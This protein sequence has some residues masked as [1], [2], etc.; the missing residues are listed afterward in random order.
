MHE[1]PVLP[2]LNLSGDISKKHHLMRDLQGLVLSVLHSMIPCALGTTPNVLV[3]HGRTDWVEV[4]NKAAVKHVCLLSLSDVPEEV[5]SPEWQPTASGDCFSQWTSLKLSHMVHFPADSLDAFLVVDKSYENASSIS[6]QK[7]NGNSRWKDKKRKRSAASENA[8]TNSGPCGVAGAVEGVSL[9]DADF[10]SKIREYVLDGVSLGAN[11]YPLPTDE[12]SL[13][14]GLRPRAYSATGDLDGVL[15]ANALLDAMLGPSL[16][17][18]EDAFRLLEDCVAPQGCSTGYVQTLSGEHSRKCAPLVA[19]DCE[20]CVTSAG[21]P[22]LTRV[23]VVGMHG[24]V[25]LDELVKPYSPIVDY[26]TRF[27]GITPELLGPITTRIEQIQIAILRM[28]DRETIIVGHSL[29]NDLH[30]LKIAHATVVDTALIFSSNRGPEFKPA[31]RVLAREHLSRV[32]QASTDGH[33]SAEV[34]FITLLCVPI[35]CIT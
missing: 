24:E 13:R 3:E 6:T 23:T 15:D 16:P 1:I 9:S 20:M 14:S 22:E 4:C 34:W 32:I 21:K 7:V 8:V 17:S 18:S 29:E 28:I 25:L 2:K 11:A 26:C 31:L 12:A 10:L 33:S 19:I 27:S 5:F 30:A 35:C